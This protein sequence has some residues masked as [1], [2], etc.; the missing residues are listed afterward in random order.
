MF[1]QCAPLLP[2]V[3]ALHGR[4]RREWPAI[5]SPEGT[6]SWAAFDRQTNRI[7][8][9]LV[10]AGRRR[11][12]RVALVMA[13]G[14]AMMEIMVGIMKAGCLVVP[15]NPASADNAIHAMLADA[16][17]SMVFATADHAHRIAPLNGVSHV[18]ASTQPIEAIEGW[19]SYQAW[20]GDIGDTSPTMV[21][22]PDD[23][24]NIIYSSGTTGEPKG[25]V[26]THQ[27]RLNWAHDLALALRYHSGAR[28]LVVTGLYSNIS[29]G[30]VLATLLAGGT[31]VLRHAFNPADTLATM[32]RERITHV[33]MVPVQFE[34]LLEHPTFERTDRS[35]M[36]AMMCCGSPLP[37]ATKARLFETFSCGVTELYG[38]TEGVITTLAP[39]EVNGR[40][41]SV[42]R[43]LPGSDI[44]I[45]G[46]DDRP[47]GAGEAGEVV[48][49]SRFVMAG[50]WRKPEATA[51]AMWADN[52]GRYWLRS[53][54]IGRV[55][56]QG[57][58]YIVD[59][60]KDMI[61]SGGQNIYPADLESVL[62]Q[63][64][65]VLECAVIGV[66][67][68]VWG[69]SPLALVTLKHGADI[70]GDEIRLWL[71]ERVGKQQ[72]VVGVEIRSDLPRNATGK[73]LKRELR[74]PY[75]VKS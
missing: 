60:K 48:G 54:D 32:A 42:G 61:V 70:S 53:G 51:A 12:D 56:E 25:I 49:R 35:S 20:L 46:P 73:L 65:D 55:D 66:P 16:G 50:Y 13:N 58:L 30:V 1:D 52:D 8:N 19:Q 9:R 34:R 67:S 24:C 63:H 3:V 6:L 74:A 10:A 29:W 44:L 75:W 33:G 71:N 31:I 64:P 43:P 68:D 40:L 26:H 17:A 47:V 21:I 45:L 69:E 39:E 15:L 38:S 57:Y 23:F 72:R 5:V 27:T 2:D 59:R 37:A 11:G 7:A 28:T 4:W 14:L 41:A 22:G 62:I 18:V 36:Q